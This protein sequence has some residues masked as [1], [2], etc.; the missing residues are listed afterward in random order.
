MVLRRTYREASNDNLGLIAAGVAFY[1]FLAMVPL[2]GAMVLMYGLVID[3]H[4]AAK[5][6]Q[7]ITAMVPGDAAKLIDEQLKSVVEAAAGKKGLGLALA[8]VLAIYGAMKGAGAVVT[9]I[10]IAY[11]QEETRGFIKT[12]L[13][14][15][16]VTLAAVV[17]AVALLLSASVTGFLEDL[18]H[19]L[20]EGSIMSIKFATW[21]VTAA[22][23]SAAVAGLYRFAPARSPAQ[24][25]WLTPGSLLATLGLVATSLGFGFYAAKFGN[26]N[27]T[28][29]SL[30]AVV[31]LLMWLYLSAYVLLLGAE[32]N[33][34]LEHQTARDTTTGQERP[35]GERGAKM[36]DE[37]A[38]DEHNRG[39][40]GAADFSAT[41]DSPGGHQALTQW[42]AV[43][44]TLLKA[45]KLFSDLRSR[46]RGRRNVN[47]AP[48]QYAAGQERGRYPKRSGVKQESDTRSAKQ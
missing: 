34:E 28:Y 18:A 37:V 3:P 44:V 20:G 7:A 31:V 12:S 32:F 42:I 22:L 25:K 47:D 29:G 30:G 2:L 35:L 5:H 8:L 40:R 41:R 19:G 39:E 48:G 16:A 1:G 14:S 11:E 24:W 4:D 36:A 45:W 27:A 21:C 33:A 46:G 26:Y 17:M 15:A 23:A 6:M 43:A 38:L 9:A 10:N 13:I